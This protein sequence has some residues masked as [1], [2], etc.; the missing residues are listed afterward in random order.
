[1]YN[2]YIYIYEKKK[3]IIKRPNFSYNMYPPRSGARAAGE[4]NIPFLRPNNHRGAPT[5]HHHHTSV[6]IIIFFFSLAR[7]LRKPVFSLPHSVPLYIHNIHD[8]SRHLPTAGAYTR[9]AY[10]NTTTRALAAQ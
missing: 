1:M 5:E 10:T 8:D 4:Y 6:F 2:I 7:L 3:I 9:A